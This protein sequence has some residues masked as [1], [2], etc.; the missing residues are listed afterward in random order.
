MITLP[1]PEVLSI[2]ADP[3]RL[4]VVWIKVVCP[5]C[6]Q[7]HAHDSRLGARR[8]FWKTPHCVRRLDVE[9]AC[10]LVDLGS[11]DGEAA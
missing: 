2:E 4:G 5:R 8:A 9:Q 10:Y 1:S 6:C 11:P 7:V 3:D